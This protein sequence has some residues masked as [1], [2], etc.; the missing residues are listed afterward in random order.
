[1]QLHKLH[2]IIERIAQYNCI[3]ELSWII[4]LINLY[5][6]ENILILRYGMYNIN[7]MCMPYNCL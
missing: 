5:Y 1:M 3:F 7:K 4:E 2:N 6:Y